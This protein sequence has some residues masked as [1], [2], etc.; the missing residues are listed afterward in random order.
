M[1]KSMANS[2]PR[3]THEEIALRTRAIYEHKGK[4]PGHDLE[5]W[6]EAEAQLM[7]LRNV[8]KQQR[9]ETTATAKLAH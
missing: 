3:P 5:N 6:L 2:A 4:V 7:S 9:Q 1:A 8:N